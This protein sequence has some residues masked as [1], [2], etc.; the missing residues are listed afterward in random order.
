MGA[1]IDE[2]KPFLAYGGAGA[3]RP[4]AGSPHNNKRLQA[5]VRRRWPVLLAASLGGLYLFRAI[6]G[7]GGA[8]SDA[9]SARL[10]AG[11]RVQGCVL[12][13]PL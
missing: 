10:G 6:V 2:H 8:E 7:P 1:S 4:A 11:G 9:G 5:W 12:F 3:R 13:F